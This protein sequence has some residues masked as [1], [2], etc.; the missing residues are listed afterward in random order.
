MRALVIA[1]RE[2][3]T[4]LQDKADLAFSLLLPIAI[5]T[6]MY[7]AFGGQLLFQGTAHVVNEDPEGIYST[8]FL[9][10]LRGIENLEVKLLSSKEAEERLDRSDLL[11]VLRVPK[12]FSNRLASG[13]PAELI[14]SQRGDAGQEGQIVVSLVRAV[15]EE[16][17][18]EFKVREQVARALAGRNIS[19]ERT[20]TVLQKFMDRERAN[21]ILGVQEELVGTRPD[22][23]NMFL[24]GIITMFVL[25]AITLNART[26][27]EERR[28]GTLERLLTTQLTV[29]ELFTGKFLAG[30]AR[31]FLQTLILLSLSQVA[32]HLFTPLTFAEILIVALIFAAAVSALGLVIASV[33]RTEDGAIWIAVFFTMVMVM[34]GGTFFS[35]SQGS[36]LYPL[37][38]ISI[39]TYAND[40][41]KAIIAGEGSLTHLRRELGIMA[42]IIIGGLG[43]GRVFFRIMPGGR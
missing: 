22:P 13:D 9:E 40:A 14:L 36:P 39:N 21:P 16:M 32:F 15:A 4:Y 23:V 34:L 26:L 3:R 43:V 30:L 7:A 42:G 37:S 11:L 19:Q 8:L 27:L 29:G 38:R 33:A 18:E 31:G 24:P 20:E 1:F 28:E 35:I 5:F 12:G 6:L 2:V 17:G 41:F 25:F 10:R